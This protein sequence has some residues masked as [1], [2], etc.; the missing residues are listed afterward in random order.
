MQR[1]AIPGYRALGTQR[2]LIQIVGPREC[3][4]EEAFVIV[5][6]VLA[7]ERFLEDRN[8]DALFG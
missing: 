6:P 5:Q 1:L 3:L 2:A 7:L 4:C 8:V